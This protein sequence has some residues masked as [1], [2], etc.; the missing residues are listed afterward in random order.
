MI[1]L[2]PIKLDTRHCLTPGEELT[3]KQQILEILGRGNIVV[4]TKS[5]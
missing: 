2:H 3:R 4:F 1:P 5:V